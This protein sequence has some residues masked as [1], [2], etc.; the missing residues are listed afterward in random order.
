MARVRHRGG[1]TFAEIRSRVSRIST[2]GAIQIASEGSS[3]LTGQTQGFFR[4]GKT[5]YGDSRPAGKSGPLS[6]YRTGATARM[7]QFVAIGTRLR[8]AL[9]TEYARYL[10]RYGILPNSRAAIP[11]SFRRA[12]D[13]IA[14]RVIGGSLT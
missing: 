6:L 7:L 13:E 12:L 14:A 10:I 5:V 1:L 9:G 11:V 2:Q 4:A 3:A 8:A